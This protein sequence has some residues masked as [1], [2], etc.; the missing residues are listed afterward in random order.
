M[1][2]C[3]IDTLVVLLKGY[4]RLKTTPGAD[5]RHIASLKYIL[6]QTVR[7]Y[8]VPKSQ[9]F[10]SEEAEKR[11]NDLTSDIIDKFDYKQKFTC[12]RLSKATYFQIFK[13]SQKKGMPTLIKNGQQICF[14]DMFHVDHIVP[15]K[16]ILSEL[17]TLK[18]INS[19]DV[20][21]ILQKMY[22]CRILKE[23]DRKIGRTSGRTLCYKYNI[24][25][26]YNIYGIIV[27]DPNTGSI[28][29]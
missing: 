4:Q 22:L 8:K 6:G 18:V 16:L 25:N 24:V 13:G 27:K 23:E 1:N 3:I 29:P 21:N 12:D 7:A 15:V 19:H 9:T 11:W 14:N 2:N 20:C 5:P 26:V 17:L 28:V 10:I